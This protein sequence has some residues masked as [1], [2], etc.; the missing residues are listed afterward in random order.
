MVELCLLVFPLFPLRWL[1][2]SVFKLP[3]ADSFMTF[4]DLIMSL[5]S[6]VISH[7]SPNPT[8]SWACPRIKTSAKSSQIFRQFPPFNLPFSC[9]HHFQTH[10]YMDCL[11]VKYRLSLY[12]SWFNSNVSPCLLLTKTWLSKTWLSPD[13]LTRAGPY[14]G[15]SLRKPLPMSTPPRPEA[16]MADIGITP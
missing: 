13:R 2:S 6:P 7:R 3:I 1:S 5:V 14:Q 10:P 8:P 12:F 9:I 15:A 4:L 11:L 16:D